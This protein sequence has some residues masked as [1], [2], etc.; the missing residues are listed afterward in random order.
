M[1]GLTDQEIEVIA[2]GIAA[3]L[4]GGD[5]A[6]KGGGAPSVPSAAGEMGIF[7]TLDDALEWV[8]DR[9][10]AE[11]HMTNSAE[12]TALKLEEID[13][14]HGID[15]DALELLRI[16]AEPRTHQAGETIFKMGDGGDELFLIRKGGVRIMLQLE[17]GRRYSLTA[18]GR[19]DFFGDMAFLDNDTRSA[20]AIAVVPT[21]VFAIS[22]ARFDG[23]A[24]PA[25]FGPPPATA[26]GRFARHRTLRGQSDHRRSAT[27]V[28]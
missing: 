14:L 6:A 16:C 26:R 22:R 20:D 10:L 17:G 8:E 15:E 24:D 7:D 1:A 9:I 12:Q 27:S 5:G 13:L 19:G 2:Q 3:D 18:F 11:A 23:R 25:I 21:E 28:R 4:R